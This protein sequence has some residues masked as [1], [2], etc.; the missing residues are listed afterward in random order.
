M[1]YG[2]ANMGGYFGAEL[3]KAGYDAL[4][5]TGKAKQPTMMRVTPER[6]KDC[7]PVICGGS[8]HQKRKGF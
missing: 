3:A 2:Y 5:V 8:P 1:A 4:V 7:P 6:I